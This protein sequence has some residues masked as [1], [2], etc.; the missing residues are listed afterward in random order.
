MKFFG[1]TDIGKVRKN[2]E[3]SFDVDCFNDSTV[4]AVVCDGMGG[5]KAGE[6]AS[7]LAT[8]SFMDYLN[9][10][11]KNKIPRNKLFYNKSLEDACK[12]ANGLVYQ[13]STFDSNYNGM[14]T[15][16][17][18]AIIKKS[19]AYIINAGDSRAYKITK[20]TIK[21]ITVDHSLVEEMF[22]R[23]EITKEEAAIHPQ[24]NIITS[25]LGVNGDFKRN[26]YHINLRKGDR[27]LLCSDG[28]TNMINDET[29]L[30]ESKR[31]TDVK[32][33]CI[34]YKDLALALGAKDNLTAV[35]IEI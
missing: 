20:R 2:N 15:T 28:I 14:G 16:L 33:L 23:G 26:I 34:A 10:H 32:D 11:L 30:N 18:G 19:R 24:K 7:S 29:L 6:L 9:S 3:D 25:A 13:Y 17:V 27:L 21:Q 22:Q 31:Y 5:A 35:I 1:I 8:K 12:E 4:I